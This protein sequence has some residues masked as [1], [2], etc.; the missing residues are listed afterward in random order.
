MTSRKQAVDRQFVRFLAILVAGVFALTTLSV[1]PAS[2]MKPGAWAN[3]WKS[4]KAEFKAKTGKK[5]PAKTVLKAFRKSSGIDKSLK[6]LDKSFAAIDTSK[7]T[8]KAVKRFEKSLKKFD[9]KKDAYIKHLKAALSKEKSADSAY[10]KGL[11]I[12]KSDLKAI[13]AAADGQLAVF[14]KAAESGKMTR[15]A[16]DAGMVKLLIGTIKEGQS[17][18]KKVLSEKTAK[19]QQIRF[20]KGIMTS[21][22]NVTQNLT[23]IAKKMDKADKR[24]KRGENLSKVLSA[25]GNKGRKLPSNATEKQI[26]REVGAYKQALKGALKWAKSL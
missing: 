17:F 6:A 23:N 19:E 12:L 1:T 7:I 4:S 20:D 15:E 26:K 13:S 11:K 25:W 18:C 24:K 8:V 22:R 2:A 21:A 9:A 10:A 14:K 3:E 16:F 5:K